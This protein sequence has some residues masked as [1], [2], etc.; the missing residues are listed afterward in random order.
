M[1][2]TAVFEGLGEYWGLLYG[3]WAASEVLFALLLRTPGSAGEVQD[4]GSLLVLWPV[5]AVSVGLGTWWAR[6]HAHAMLGG[7]EW[8]K[9]TGF[10]MLVMG[11]AIRWGAVLALGR[12]FGGNTVIHAE[13]TVEKRGL[14]RFVRHPAS[15]GLILVFAGIGL[16]GRNWVGM[17]LVMVPGAIALLHR[18]ELEERALREAFGED[19]EEYVEKTSRL[20][21][22]IY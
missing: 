13:Q 9:T 5:I 8:L 1:S 14:F 3:V 11:L 12:T 20:I 22:F 19:Y 17:G 15:L 21:P 4:R 10:A 16:H 6:G 18:M 7:G 2:Q